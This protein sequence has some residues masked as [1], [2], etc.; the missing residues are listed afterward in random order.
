MRFV[1][2]E[3]ENFIETSNE[4]EFI[5]LKNIYSKE[6]FWER[7]SAFLDLDVDKMVVQAINNL[8]EH[9]SSEI[10]YGLAQSELN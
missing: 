8:Y 4:H 3:N 10:A 6:M 7:V 5:S 1:L 2:S 9:S